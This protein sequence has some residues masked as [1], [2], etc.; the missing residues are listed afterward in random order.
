MDDAPRPGLLALAG[1]T[2]FLA[3]LVGFA[4]FALGLVVAARAGRRRHALALFAAAWLPL[5]LAFAGRALGDVAAFREIVALGPAVTPKDVA[6]G[7]QYGSASTW[8]AHVAILLGLSGA[9]AALAR[10][11]EDGPAGE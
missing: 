9:V 1:P 8:C 7:M 2:G 6:A 5:P 10:S 4:V 3:L 11:R